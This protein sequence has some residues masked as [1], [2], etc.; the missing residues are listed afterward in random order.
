MKFLDADG[1]KCVL[2]NV[3]ETYYDKS[4]IDNKLKEAAE[5]KFFNIS[6]EGTVTVKLVPNREIEITTEP[7]V[8]AQE[9]VDLGLPTGTL[10]SKYNVGANSEEE[11]G[12]RFSWGETEGYATTTEDKKFSWNDYKF[13]NE[14][15]RTKYN[16]EDGLTSLLLED[17]AAHV[18]LGGDWVMPSRNDCDELMENTTHAWV[19]NYNESGVNGILFK[20][21]KNNNELFIPAYGYISNGSISGLNTQSCIWL[22]N[23]TANSITASVILSFGA[24]SSSFQ[25]YNRRAGL[26]IRGVV[27]PTYRY[28]SIYEKSFTDTSVQIALPDSITKFEEI[29]IEGDGKVTKCESPLLVDSGYSW[30]S[31]VRHWS[32]T[33]FDYGQKTVAANKYSNNLKS[34]T[35][36]NCKIL[37]IGEFSAGFSPVPC[38]PFTYNVDKASNMW[39]LWCYLN[40]DQSFDWDYFIKAGNQ[41]REKHGYFPL[42]HGLCGRGVI[43]ND[44]AN[45]DD[46]YV[47]DDNEYPTPAMITDRTLLYAFI[48]GD[49]NVN[50]I[51]WID[52]RYCTSNIDLSLPTLTKLLVS[53]LKVGLNLTH[54]HLDDKSIGFMGRLAKQVTNKTITFSGYN[55]YRMTEV[56][57]KLFTDKGF[58]IA[59]NWDGDEIYKFMY[60][61]NNPTALAIALDSN[62]NKTLIAE[63][64][65][66]FT[67]ADNDVN[68]RTF[69]NRIITND[70]SMWIQVTNEYKEDFEKKVRE[71]KAR[72]LEEMMKNR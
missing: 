46:K 41:I 2:K 9:Y 12:L 37:N 28:K 36:E 21:K 42:L 59:V 20:S 43:L 15:E 8:N 66:W 5:F 52:T 54:A 29:V 61:A 14:T 45:V 23:T 1:L 48:E 49:A 26:I 51:G 58:N 70:A 62:E 50:T 65:M 19:T 13:G 31:S 24:D 55:F 40:T 34:F 4:T 67:E 44:D 72:E 30:M 27:H 57:K 64:G 35:Q 10:W 25:D 39:N 53:N 11:L 38:P 3:K 71:E 68:G 16:L 33:T 60:D 7:D 22:S 56:Q 47:L 6:V 17:D 63:D 18:C 69:A 32:N